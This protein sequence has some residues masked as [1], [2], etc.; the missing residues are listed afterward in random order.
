MSLVR[1][2]DRTLWH[3]TNHHP[4]IPPS[5]RFPTACSTQVRMTIGPSK[6]DHIV[7]LVTLLALSHCWP[8]HID[9]MRDNDLVSPSK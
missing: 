1:L 2:R 6:T 5:M 4:L 9:G 7:G 8:D 3:T